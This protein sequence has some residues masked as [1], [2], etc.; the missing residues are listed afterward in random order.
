MPICPALPH[1][2]LLRQS[3]WPHEHWPAQPQPTQAARPGDSRAWQPSHPE[4]I[5]AVLLLQAPPAASQRLP[6]PWT[7]RFLSQAE[8]L[9]VAGQWSSMT[10]LRS[11]S[12]G[13]AIRPADTLQTAKAA[14]PA[15]CESLSIA[16]LPLTSS[17]QMLSIIAAANMSATSCADT[18]SGQPPV[19]RCR[20]AMLG[21]LLVISCLH[22]VHRGQAE[23]CRQT[24]APASWVRGG[25][26][27]AEG[28][29]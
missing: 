25:P 1:L 23:M 28:A 14:K 13:T 3:R 15:S 27:R 21:F 6:A 7:H 8:P 2:G 12:Q 4:C 16:H 26:A 24:T 17:M 19:A 9:T 20:G 18:T 29:A 22:R 10:R 5:Q 11:T